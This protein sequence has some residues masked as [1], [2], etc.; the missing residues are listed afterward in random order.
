M[1]PREIGDA[2]IPTTRVYEKINP[3]MD[4]KDSRVQVAGTLRR[5]HFID[6]ILNPIE[7]IILPSRMFG[8]TTSRHSCIF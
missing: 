5:A 7:G 3:L 6:E 4:D 1:P 2:V 8:L